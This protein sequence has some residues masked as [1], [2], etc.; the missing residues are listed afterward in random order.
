MVTVDGHSHRD[1]LGISQTLFPTVLNALATAATTVPTSAANSAD[2]AAN[3]RQELNNLQK[4]MEES[5]QSFDS[6]SVAR[7]RK[8]GASRPIM[9]SDQKKTP[10]AS[11][12][13]I[14]HAIS[15][16]NN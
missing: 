10:A 1:P 14:S 3:D 2:S 15:A 9:I 6:E 5:R 11:T 12:N 4:A 8:T 16:A 13:T 7:G